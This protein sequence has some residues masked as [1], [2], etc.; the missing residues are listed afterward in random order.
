[1]MRRHA[2]HG[3]SLL[4]M[5]VAVF[6][7]VFIVGALYAL[8]RNQQ[9]QFLYQDL[10][11]EMHQNGRLAIDVLSR[12]GRAAGSGTIGWTAG[13]FGWDGNS[14]SVMP[15]II[16]YNNTGPNGSDA[17]TLVSME[18]SLLVETMGSFVPACN[19]DVLN[20]DPGRLLIRERLEQ[21]NEGD[22]MLCYDYTAPS[23]GRSFMWPVTAEPVATDGSVYITNG[24]ASYGDYAGACEDG[25]NLPP[26]M[27]CSRAQV[28]TYYIDADDTDGTGTGSAAHP[29]LMM[30]L[31]F[32]SPD[33]D[34][35]PVVEDV[36]DLQIQY[37][38]SRNDCASAG[39]WENGVDTYSDPKSDNDADD[40]A[41]IRFLVTIR[42]SRTDPE[43]LYSG[44]RIDVADNT[45]W[46]GV[47][48][49]YFRQVL[50]IEVA[51]RNMRLLQV[52]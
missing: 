20:F 31:D 39:G 28:V 23:G 37:C 10:Q 41:M 45:G 2:R 21:I 14:D 34:D 24:V 43:R 13:V 35:V 50:S 22:V 1:M 25:Q 19:T 17:I 30:D 47:E 48:D 27:T 44:H 11:M 5:M 8:F 6:I 51:V 12:S 3:F 52:Q 9:R 4:E 32:Q 38:M 33:D 7:G 18:P 49:E 15:A 40:V 16:S 36:E 26:A 46:T 29:T 42:S